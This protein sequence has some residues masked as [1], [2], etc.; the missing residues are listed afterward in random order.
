[1]NYVTGGHH[2]AFRV[3]FQTQP[4]VVVDGTR[5]P[6]EFLAAGQLGAPARA[7]GQAT[8]AGVGGPPGRGAARRALATRCRPAGRDWVRSLRGPGARSPRGRRP[9]LAPESR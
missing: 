4:A 5:G 8:G 1:M 3:G 2:H 7:D 6:D 9:L